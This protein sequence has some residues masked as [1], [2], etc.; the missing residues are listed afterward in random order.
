LSEIENTPCQS[1]KHYR[2]RYGLSRDV[3]VNTVEPLILIEVEASVSWM[4]EPSRKPDSV[5][6]RL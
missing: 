1:S 5:L 3:V 2:T 6:W 4:I